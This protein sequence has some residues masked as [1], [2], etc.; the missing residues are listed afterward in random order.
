VLGGVIG[1]KAEPEGE[2]D[3][4]LSSVK[5]SGP[6]ADECSEDLEAYAERREAPRPNAAVKWE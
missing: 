6:S 2:A 3:S 4:V 1:S 5:L